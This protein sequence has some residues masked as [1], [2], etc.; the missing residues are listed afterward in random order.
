[1]R[2]LDAWIATL[3][4]CELLPEPAVKRLCGAAVELLVEEPNVVPVDA[5]VTICEL[6]GRRRVGAASGEVG[7][8]GSFFPIDQTKT[9]FPTRRRHTRPVLRLDGAVCDGGRPTADGVPVFR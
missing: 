4:K 6:W 7:E 8:K 9:L 5:P 3:S 2:D 1:M